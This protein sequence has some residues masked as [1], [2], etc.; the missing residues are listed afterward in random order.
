MATIKS[1]VTKNDVNEVVKLPL[2]NK[3]K[4]YVKDNFNT[5]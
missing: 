4:E 1:K 3:I 5:L 2:P